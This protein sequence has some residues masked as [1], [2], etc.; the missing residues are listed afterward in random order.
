MTR[1]R[2]GWVLLVT[3]VKQKYDALIGYNKNYIALA[4]SCMLKNSKETFSA[5]ETGIKDKGKDI[6]KD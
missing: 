3:K 6:I 2:T 1:A 4:S 5:W